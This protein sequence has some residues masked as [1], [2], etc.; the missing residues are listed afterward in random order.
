MLDKRFTQL[1]SVVRDLRRGRYERAYKQLF[2]KKPKRKLKGP[3]TKDRAAGLWLEWTYG[4]SPLT[5]DIYNAVNDLVKTPR[6]LIL[7]CRGRK[8]RRSDAIVNV[9]TAFGGI[10]LIPLLS[11]NIDVK[12]HVGLTYVSY[13]RVDNAK[14]ASASAAGLTNPAALVWELIPFSFVFDWFVNVGDVLND[15][16]IAN[17]LTHLSTVR[18]EK[19]TTT[20]RAH[21]PVMMDYTQATSYKAKA[22]G[23]V[24]FYEERSELIRTISPTRPRIYLGLNTQPLSI[25]RIISAAALLNQLGKGLFAKGRN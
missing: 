24:D 10:D 20:A 2:G 17:G 22:V 4:W 1:I 19:R 11:Y 18:S 25:R 9:S 16:T 23:T 15:I 21:G 3:R 13:Y 7:R 12:R 6:P 8:G 14:F 5:S